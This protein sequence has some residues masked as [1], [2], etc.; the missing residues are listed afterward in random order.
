MFLLFA[1][2]PKTASKLRLDHGSY[3]TVSDSVYENSVAPFFHN[4]RAVNFNHDFLIGIHSVRL[5]DKILS[6]VRG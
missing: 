6:M 2:P 5:D 3:S 1:K 4:Y